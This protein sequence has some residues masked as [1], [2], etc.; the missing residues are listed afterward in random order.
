MILGTGKNSPQPARRAGKKGG[1]NRDSLT[2]VHTTV[3]ITTLAGIWNGAFSPGEI[4]LLDRDSSVRRLLHTHYEI[5][6]TLLE[7]RQLSHAQFSG[8][9]RVEGAIPRPN[10]RGLPRKEEP[11]CRQWTSRPPMLP[12]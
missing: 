5:G 4:K 8:I 11:I 12:A 7:Q 6:V 10:T 9:S 2:F 3:A 1:E